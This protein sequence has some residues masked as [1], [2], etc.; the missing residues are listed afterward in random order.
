MP[1]IAQPVDDPEIET[2]EMMPAFA[3]DVVDIRR[4]GGV[5]DAIT[6]GRNIAVPQSK[7]RKR[8]RTALPFDRA[9]LTGFDEVTVQDRRIVAFRWRHETIGKPQQDLIGGRLAQIDRNTPALMQHDG[10]EIV[11]AVGLVGMLMRQ[12][13]RV[14]VIDL[15]VDQL[16]AQGIAELRESLRAQ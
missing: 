15:G 5:T 16:L 1:G 6:E 9:A 4:I 8:H 14:N 13:Y 2:F 11:D 12:E 10:T 7:R 3:R